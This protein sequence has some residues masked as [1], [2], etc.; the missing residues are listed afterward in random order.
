MKIVHAVCPHD[1]PDACSLLV[2]VVRGRVENIRGDPDHPIT[3]GFLCVKVNNYLDWVYNPLR[4]LH[5]RRRIGP[6]GSDQW[7]QITW[8]EA[9]ATIAERFSEI[10][11]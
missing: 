11:I 10:A 4:V 1:C 3:R 6:K 8:E 2:T 5:P 9:I 7:Q